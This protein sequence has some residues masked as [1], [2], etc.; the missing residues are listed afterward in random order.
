MLKPVA[1]MVMPFGK[2]A[3]DATGTS[4][5]TEVDFDALWDRVYDPVLTG[6]GYEA[7][8]ADQDLGALVI[9]EMIQRLTIADLVLADL[10]LPN[11]NVYYELGIRH[12]AKRQGCVIVAAEWANP[13]F[14]L[15]QMRR[16][17]FALN[18][19][20]IPQSEAA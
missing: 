12:A 3:V 1:F 13:P 14:D 19:G 20:T 18:D 4:S 16:V 6:L 8:R 7:V 17:P 11:A 2:K 15:V 9:T 5:P 10:T